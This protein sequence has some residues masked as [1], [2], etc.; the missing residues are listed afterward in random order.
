MASD[1]VEHL[2]EGQGPHCDL[3]GALHLK[4]RL[5]V[6]GNQEFFTHEDSSAY[7]R[8]AAKVLQ[9]APHQDGA[10]ALLTEG[11]VDGQHVDVNRRPVRFMEGEGVLENKHVFIC[12]APSAGSQPELRCLSQ[13]E[14]T[15]GVLTRVSLSLSHREPM[16][17]ATSRP[18]SN[19]PRESSGHRVRKCRTSS[20]WRGHSPDTEMKAARRKN[21]LSLDKLTD[22]DHI[23]PCL[24]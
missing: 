16:M 17:K 8:Q 20:R 4:T 13:V 5:L 1:R 10:F 14:L 3:T 24:F 22:T 6:K 9:I 21:V 12:V 23:I 19:Q 18:S 11:P 15:D 2:N 7:T